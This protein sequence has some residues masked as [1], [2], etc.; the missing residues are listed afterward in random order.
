MGS[1]MC[2]RDRTQ[3]ALADLK[4]H[5]E[6]EYSRQFSRIVPGMTIEIL[7]WG[8]TVSSQ[9]PTLKPALRTTENRIREATESREIICDVSGETILAGVFDRANLQSGDQ[10]IGPALIIEA[11]TTILVS[12]DFSAFMDLGGNIWMTQRQET[13]E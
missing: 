9:A 7:N 12:T 11:Q 1:E 10:I 5:F 8:V 13:M 2:I 4:N 6:L 3:A